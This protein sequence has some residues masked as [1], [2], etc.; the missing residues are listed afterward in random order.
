MRAENPDRRFVEAWQGYDPVFAEMAKDALESDGIP[1]RIRGTQ[2]AALLGAGQ[3]AFSV[4]IDVPEEDGPRA[5]ELLREL[6][7]APTDDDDDDDDETDDREETSPASVEGADSMP[8]LE[9]AAKDR[10]RPPRRV[11]AGPKGRRGRSAENAKGAEKRSRAAAI[12]LALV[13]PGFGQIYVRRG[14]AG[15]CVL[16]GIALSVA[17]AAVLQSL[18]HFGLAVSFS[19]VVDAVAGQLGVSA[20]A[21]GERMEPVR[22]WL[23]GA[24]QVVLI[25]VAAA[26]VALLAVGR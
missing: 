24:G 1:A 8:R 5:I 15:L 14:Y 25:Q 19:M 10:Y 21:R 9:S 2:N 7:R 23:V 6:P 20:L 26:S 4:S 16:I 13:F 3:Y 17:V 11:D 18:P 22:Q 12:G